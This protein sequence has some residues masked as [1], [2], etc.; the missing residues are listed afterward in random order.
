MLFLS[1]ALVVRLIAFYSSD[2]NLIRNSYTQENF[3]LSGVKGKMVSNVKRILPENQAAL[4]LGIVF[5]EKGTFDK[6]YFEAIRKTGVLHVIAASGM[7]ISMVASFLIT[8]LTLFLKRQKALV[9]SSIAIILYASLADFQPSIVRASIMAIFAFSAG[10]IGRQNT[11][12]LA[13]FFAGF[14]MVMFDPKIIE[15]I[16]FQL[17]FVATLGIILLDPIFKKIGSNLLFEDARATISAQIATVPILLFFFGTYSPISIVANFLVL[18]TIPP[19]MILGAFG[20]VLS[21]ASPL[22][23]VPFLWL[24]MPL[25]IFF[26]AIVLSLNR[27]ASEIQIDSLPWVLI[28]GYYLILLAL[29]LLIYKKKN[30]VV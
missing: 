1:L 16:G 9:L 23:A 29:I 3:V 19:L 18:W 10:V 6:S 17:S 11:S 8:S 20:A 24:S 15:D 12:L 22:I 26:E 2:R 7:N 27:Y 13:L 5:G 14:I 28:A 4:I 30:I 21:L 25:L